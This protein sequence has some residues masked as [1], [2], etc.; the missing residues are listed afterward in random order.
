MNASRQLPEHL[1]RR[2]RV[3]AV[4]AALLL[5]ATASLAGLLRQ[6]DSDALCSN[7]V[8]RQLASPDGSLK[9]VTFVRDCGATTSFSVQAAFLP[10]ADPLPT[11][12]KSFFVADDDHGRAPIDSTG[13]PIVVVR[14][15]D[16]QSMVLRYPAPARIFKADTSSSGIRI[17]Y[18]PING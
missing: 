1:T 18:S 17:H 15:R 13:V 9:I 10:V 6:T 2:A 8:I 3:F 16:A 14:W 7:E 4:V 12:P 5:V 11:N